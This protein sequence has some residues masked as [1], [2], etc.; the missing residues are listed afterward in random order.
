MWKFVI[1]DA[2]SLLLLKS[3]PAKLVN[4]YFL[5]S[6]PSIW[7]SATS[8]S[9]Q[10]ADQVSTVSSVYALLNNEITSAA[11]LAGGVGAA[12]VGSVAP[13]PVL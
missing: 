5:T 8:E 11:S 13:A 1:P 2:S 7:T 3:I 9:S 10:S 12:T 6:S 4:V